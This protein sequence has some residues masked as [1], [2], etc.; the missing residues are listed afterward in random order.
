MN[1]DLNTSPLT[2][3]QS[4]IVENISSLISSTADD[5]NHC[6]LT[7]P[8][9]NK[10]TK[11]SLNNEE[12]SIERAR[13]LNDDLLT[14][15]IPKRPFSPENIANNDN[16][17]PMMQQIYNKQLLLNPMEQN[18]L[19]NQRNYFGHNYEDL[20]P[21]E[22]DS[23]PLKPFPSSSSFYDDINLEGSSK[24]NQFISNFMNQLTVPSLQQPNSNFFETDG[25]QTD[26]D[27]NVK[28]KKFTGYSRSSSNL[29]QINFNDM[30]N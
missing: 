14:E 21:F 4:W 16:G 11:S 1:S 19:V 17:L 15:R 5:E 22:F 6:T 29:P 12:A 27:S 20:R 7:L 2:S 10:L 28:R 8:N 24:N 30:S 9:E 3:A 25:N 13:C 18:E 26:M 23:R